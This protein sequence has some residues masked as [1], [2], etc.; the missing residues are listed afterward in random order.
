MA[1]KKKGKGKKSKS[2]VL[3]LNFKGIETASLVPEASYPITPVEIEKDESQEGNDYLAWEFIITEGKFKGQKLYH[4][5]SLLPQALWNL[6][7][8]LEAFG[9]EVPDGVM[10]LDLGAICDPENV[11]GC[12]V[13][14]D[15]FDG[16]KRAKIGDIFPVEALDD[17][18]ESDDDDEDDEDE[19]DS[20]D[21][22][23]EDDDEVT[24]EDIEGM[25]ADE[26]AEFV[27][28]NEVDVK[29][30]K[31]KSLKKKRAAVIEALFEDEEDDDDDEE[32]DD[33]DE[34]ESEDDDSEDD[35]EDNPSKEDLNIMTKD[36]LAEII[37]EYELTGVKKK[38]P[39]GKLRKSVIKAMKK[40]GSLSD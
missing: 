2:A 8:T 32:D 39:V 27:E 15:T 34:D 4:N 20:E 36:E 7:G 14:H 31:I 6:K 3:K 33:D 37:E 26:L 11:A 35:D 29:L 30:K 18:E 25:S 38:D 12:E 40:A 13:Y 16:K 21:D 22:D 17:D 28:E 19:D 5:T 9:I 10:N 24:K 1:K 23:S